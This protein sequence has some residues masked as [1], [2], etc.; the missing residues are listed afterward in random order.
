[1]STSPLEVVVD[2][3]KDFA[4]AFE[5][6]EVEVAVNELG[7]LVPVESRPPIELEA[8]GGIA[9]RPRRA[10]PRAR[11]RRPPREVRKVVVTQTR[12][13]L[14]G[15]PEEAIITASEVPQLV[16]RLEDLISKL[17]ALKRELKGG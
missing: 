14:R 10:R 6:S 15:L 16:E 8:V 4:D 1:M 9:P 5:P 3:T 11:A 17:E 12:T 7:A 13:E 2:L